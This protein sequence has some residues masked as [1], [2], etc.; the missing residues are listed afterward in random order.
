MHYRQRTPAP[1]GLAV[2]D[3]GC[4]A[5]TTFSLPSP[6]WNLQQSHTALVLL[7]EAL[8]YARELERSP[9]DFA[10]EIAALYQTGLTA[11]ALRWL[12]CKGYVEHA[13]ELTTQGRGARDFRRSEGLRF[14]RRTCFVLTEA[15][16]AFAR[17]V[18]AHSPP[19]DFQDG[20]FIERNGDGAGDVLR[21]IWDGRRQE[22]RLG[23][24]VV[25]Q[26]RVPAIN[27]KR[28]LAAF[29]EE[30][31]PPRVDDP[32]TPRPEQDP[33]RRLHDTINSLNRNQRHPLVR[34]TGDGSGQGIRWSFVPP[35]ENGN[36]KDDMGH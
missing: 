32:L 26:F 31:W 16:L 11:S 14:D 36:G 27:Q 1:S 10:V 25:K 6:A 9:W 22:L 8:G 5:E 13:C 15:G 12:V 23:P 21:P 7:L 24:Y 19:A 29:E 3:G 35:N 33:K 17:D 4:P 34:F 18:F 20:T 2:A 30:G 28:V